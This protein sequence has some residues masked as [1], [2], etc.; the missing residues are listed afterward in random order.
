MSCQPFHVY[1]QCIVKLSTF[2]V[3]VMPAFSCLQS[4]YCQTFYIYSVCLA[5]LSMLKVKFIANLW[6]WCLDLVG[7]QFTTMDIHFVYVPICVFSEKKILI[8]TIKV[9]TRNQNLDKHMPIWI[10]GQGSRIENSQ[11]YRIFQLWTLIYI[12]FTRNSLLG[13]GMV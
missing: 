13:F 5:S 4:M 12:I 6:F 9:Y 1:S 2:T 10:L 3:Y 7:H 8:I 11:I